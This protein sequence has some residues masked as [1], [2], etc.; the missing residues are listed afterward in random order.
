M[1]PS[2]SPP[3]QSPPN[4]NTSGQA[5]PGRGPLT[6]DAA[7]AAIAEVAGRATGK[8]GIAACHLESGETLSWR[9]D[10]PFSTA[11]MIK[12][13]ICAAVL[14]RARRGA[15]S[16]DGQ[17][18]VRNTDLT[19]GS[20]VLAELRPGLRCTVSDLCTL[21][22]VVSDNT[23][24][25]MLIDLCGGV[26]AVNEDFA[27]LGFPGFRLNRRISIPPPPL[28]RPR[29]GAG[30]AAPAP[31]P[32]EPAA[33]P[34]APGAPAP[35]GPLA[36]VR[37]ADFA[38]LMGKLE[39]GEIV[40]ESASAEIVRVMRYQHHQALFPR[41]YLDIAAPFRPPSAGAPA[42]AHKTGYVGG[43]RTEGGLLYLP[44]GGGTVA[45]AAAADGLTDET[46]TALAEGDEIL[47]RLGAIVLARWWA[48]PGPVPV[49]DGW[50]GD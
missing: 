16:L 6:H 24:T 12:V 10:E 29:A 15:F 42:L 37:L 17:V 13:P 11:S 9:D 44:G 22:I 5:Q 23:A 33:T 21:M 20:G 46:M 27:A 39:A 30:E 45:Y 7:L 47:G 19:G 18:T 48:G 3:S 36:T 4:A 32:G 50:L 38:E 41:A 1:P 49:R 43:C 28:V 40:D 2:Q 8:T 14:R 25:N 34:A 26:D 31:A 35:R